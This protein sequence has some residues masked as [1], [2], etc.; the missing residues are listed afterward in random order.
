MNI[1]DIAKLSG[2]SKSTVSR[3]LNNGYVSEE[4]RNKIQRVIDETGFVPSAQ[5]KILRTK[6][7]D[8]IGVILPKISSETMS[9]IVGGISE[10]ISKH[11][12]NII[13]GNTDLNIEKE[14]EYLNIFKNR[15]VDGIIFVATI[16]TDKHLQI[17]KDIKIPIV[18][19]GQY[20][21]GYPCV[22]HSDYKAAYEMTE[23]LI[24]QG[25]NKIAYIG[26]TDDDISAGLNR[27][28]GYI[29]CLKNKNLTYYKGIIRV[30]DF[31][32]ASGYNHA[33]NLL[34]NNNDIDAIFCATY[35]MALGA[36]EY[37][38]E[39]NINIPN[40]ISICAIGDS[41][42]SNLISP[43]LTTVQYYYEKSGIDSAK[44]LMD[45]ISSTVDSSDVKSIKL[46]YNLQ[47]R[48]SVK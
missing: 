25:H 45:T 6:K 7:T 29:D 5:G 13:L 42:I 36:M 8:L 2:V 10:E 48:E 44:I 47:I 43:K 1:I 39:S 23:Y 30:G 22:Y 17:I 40:K 11:G 14:I 18:I 37:A 3:F 32:Q 46:G 28:N 27:K 4:S 19:V 38:K 20:I 26:A 16:I 31:S 33:K 15:N 21:D 24:K 9:K 41:K 34:E 35:N 12:Y